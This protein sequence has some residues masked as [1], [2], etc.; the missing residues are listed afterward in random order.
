[1]ATF[2]VVLL[3]DPFD[4]D[5]WQSGTDF[6]SDSQ[7]ELVGDDLLATTIDW[8]KTAVRKE[9]C[10]S[11]LLKINQIST[12][13]EAMNVYDTTTSKLTFAECKKRLKMDGASL[14]LIGPG[15]QPMTLSP[16]SP[17]PCNVSPQKRSTLQ[18]RK[19][20]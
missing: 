18:R 8:V 19:G 17:L 1:M 10:N 15:R 16:T 4:R 9:A 3:E 2:P 6:E 11:M 14:H 5:V 20:R 12:I 13:T 7:V